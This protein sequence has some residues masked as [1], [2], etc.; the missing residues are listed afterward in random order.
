VH[1]RFQVY[2]LDDLPAVL[3]EY[4]DRPGIGLGVETE[5]G[6]RT[7]TILDDD[8]GGDGDPGG[9][10][11]MDIGVVRITG[12]EPDLELY[13]TEGNLYRSAFAEYVPGAEVGVSGGGEGSCVEPFAIDVVAVPQLTAESTS[14]TVAQGEDLVITWDQADSPAG[15]RIW[16][17][18]ATSGPDT[19][20]IECW[21]GDTGQATVPAAQLD[22][23]LP[24]L[25]S[26]DI[27]T[28]TR[29]DHATTETERGCAALQT[30][31]RLRL[32]IGR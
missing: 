23:V 20:V 15:T 5:D 7:G 8:G 22:E 10:E 9:P 14:Y 28:F 3:G 16:L 29:I 6:C 2:V 12:T 17:Y 18:A 32:D 25:D 11:A 1:A 26:F 4:D 27:V 19:D 13:A 21:W 31:T 24:G 30:W